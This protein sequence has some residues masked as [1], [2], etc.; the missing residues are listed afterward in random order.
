VLTQLTLPYADT[1]AATLQW[2]ATLPAA[3]ALD[4]I[5]LSPAGAGSARLELRLLGASH[6]AVLDVDCEQLVETVAG[7]AYGGRG[8]PLPERHARTV[9]ALCYHF[10]SRIDRLDAADL[11]TLAGRL[12]AGVQGRRDRLAGVFPGAADALTVLHGAATLRRA[13]W[14]T[15]HL[16][17]NTGELVRTVTAVDW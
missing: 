7:P 6:C 14:S 13:R 9:G 5:R 1:S 8:D 3:P 16:Y 4:L 10:V 2:S 11:S 17:P 15:W 12:R